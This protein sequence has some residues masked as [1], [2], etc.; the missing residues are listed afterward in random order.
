MERGGLLKLP[1][2]KDVLD[3]AEGASGQDAQV[4]R[5]IL[6]LLA[7][8]PVMREQM[9]ELKKDLYLVSTQI[10]D[11]VPDAQFGADVAKL[12][13]SWL[14]LA[15]GRKFSMKNFHRSREFFGLLSLVVGML[16][17]LIFLLGTRLLG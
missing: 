6:N 11:Y 16:L 4:Q 13:Q 12:T 9:A 14:Q 15:Y 1:E 3:Y 5:Q 2:R 17:L 10:P 8:S 7:S